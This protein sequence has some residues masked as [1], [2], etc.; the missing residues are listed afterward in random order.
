MRKRYY[1]PALI[2]ALLVAL[3]ALATLSARLTAGVA[4]LAAERSVTAGLAREVRAY[5]EL[6]A[7][8]ALLRDGD[9]AT[10]ERAYARLRD[11]TARLGVAAADLDSRLR[12]A[13]RLRR[14][15]LALDTL[16]VL[17]ARDLVALA[18][19][20]TPAPAVA[21]KSVAPLPLERSRPADYDSLDFALRKAQ[22]RIRNLEGRLRQRSGGNYLT[23]AS[24]QGNEVYYVGDVRDGKANGR[25]VALLSSGS[26]YAGDWTDNRRHGEGTFHWPDG[27]WYEG[28]FDDDQ[29][30]GQGTYHFP[31][32]QLFV[33]EWEGDLRDGEGVFYDADG[34]VVARGRWEDD[35]FVG[36]G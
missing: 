34:E 11:D 29:R 24:R 2:V 18:P 1:L 4:D 9:Y 32:G 21:E 5:E 3:A 25:G 10:A 27:A 23:F 14:M 19:L 26:R 15:A 36:E 7:I 16:R 17:D 31:D 30:S 20:P 22:L 33:G 6:A 35:E 8:D 13:R 12:H 28:G